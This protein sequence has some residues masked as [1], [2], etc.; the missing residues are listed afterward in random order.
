VALSS[1][2][3]M[4]VLA[5]AQ[6]VTGPTYLLASLAGLAAAVGLAA[7]LAAGRRTGPD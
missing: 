3:A 7:L 5:V 2:F 6:R 1:A 4:G